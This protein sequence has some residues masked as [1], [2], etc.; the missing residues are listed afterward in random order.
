MDSSGVNKNIAFRIEKM[1]QPHVE[2]GV[3]R[4]P[5]MAQNL[6]L[7]PGVA[8]DRQGQH[9]EDPVFPS[10]PS[11]HLRKALSL[12]SPALGRIILCFVLRTQPLDFPAVEPA[13][14]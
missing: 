6:K 3:G 13:T 9:R 7:S 14:L 11:Y 5:R 10:F 8:E 1:S 2:G 4:A 12:Q